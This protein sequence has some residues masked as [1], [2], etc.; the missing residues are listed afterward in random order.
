M[1]PE[2]DGFKVLKKIR[3][4]VK[5]RD[6]P[7]V[8]VTAKDLSVEEKLELSHM[9]VSVITKDDSTPK[10]VLDEIKRVLVQLERNSALAIPVKGKPSPRILMVEDNRDAIIQVKTVLERVGYIV[11]V[12]GGGKEALEYVKNVIPDG[13][14]LDLMMPEIDGF[15]VLKNIRN[16]EATRKIPVL[17]LTAKD[18]TKDDLNKLSANNIQQLI[19]KGDVD[20]DGLLFKVKMMLGN[21]PKTPVP[22]SLPPEDSKGKEDEN[23]AANTKVISQ[24]KD[25]VKP[26]GD[27]ML[28]NIPTILVV[29]D[30]SDNM[31]TIK[32]ILKGKY[33]I[34]EAYDGQ[35]GLQQAISFLP[36]LI[37]LDMS[38]PVIGGIDVVQKL[39]MTGATKH[40]PV[41][42]VTAQAMKGDE[43]RFIR[44]GCD[45]YV[46]KPVN[47]LLLVDEIRKLLS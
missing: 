13:I 4:D 35:Q 8:V 36:D 20:I 45:S 38:L 9:V 17:I 10:V 6:L 44:I 33:N 5:T 2:I 12:A 46:S 19:H 32:A 31:Q 47:P 16:T 26:D 34:V 27:L 24:S 29:E 25:L 40:I 1:M 30:N 37:L 11:D 15:E 7:V 22:I 42:A 21:E 23:Y 3:Q 14:I 28:K 41:I 39:K 43:Q 18:L